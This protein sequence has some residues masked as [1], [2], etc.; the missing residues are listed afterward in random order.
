MKSVLRIAIFLALLAG[1]VI[2]VLAAAGCKREGL[3]AAAA[4]G[5]YASLP[6]P[7]EPKGWRLTRE[8]Y[9][10]ATTVPGARV[11]SDA[12]PRLVLLKNFLSPEETQHFVDVNKDR[13]RPSE[14]VTAAG[15]QRDPSRTSSG[16]W[17]EED[18]VVRR[19]T[20]RIHSVAS[21]PESY[22]EQIYVLNYKRKEKYSAHNDHCMDTGD[23]PD[24]GCMR[25]LRQGGGPECG[26]EKGGPSCGD[27]LA[28]FIMYLKAPAKGG[29][30]VFP[31]SAVT[32]ARLAA[33]VD[34]SSPDWY[35]EVDEVLGVAPE[36]GD[37][38]LFWN[39]A[40][41]AGADGSGS[42]EAGTASP[43]AKRVYEAMH[44]GCPVKDG[45]KWIATRWIR[46]APMR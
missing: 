22:G 14:V 5:S 10:H 24:A 29:R 20:A 16:A 8:A 13:L 26:R 3:T 35:C 28:T 30:T 36:A 39:Y 37:A 25:M 33:D 42:Y 9:D 15:D 32:R 41:D 12:N 4:A 38:I 43:G 1:A 40:Y 46:G 11:L 34:R 19:V 31:E 27:R 7:P 6:P 21:V 18:D 23:K 2:V 45:E 44:S 17:V